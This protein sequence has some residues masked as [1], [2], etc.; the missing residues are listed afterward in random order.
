MS[1]TTRYIT[2]Q[3]KRPQSLIALAGTVSKQFPPA[4]RQEM[5][6]R[7]LASYDPVYENRKTLVEMFAANSVPVTI[8]H[9]PAVLE[10]I[11]LVAEYVTSTNAIT[12]VPET[13]YNRITVINELESLA[14][15]M[16]TSLNRNDALFMASWI[17]ANQMINISENDV[18]SFQVLLAM[19][20]II[21]NCVNL[22]DTFYTDYDLS[23]TG[24][25]ETL[26][27]NSSSNERYVLNDVNSNQ[28]VQIP[29]I[30][31]LVTCYANMFDEPERHVFTEECRC[32]SCA[33]SPRYHNFLL[34]SYRISN[35]IATPV[36]LT[37]YIY[38][39]ITDAFRAVNNMV[40]AGK[41]LF[42]A[43]QVY[44]VLICNTVGNSELCMAKTT[45]NDEYFD[46]LM[47]HFNHYGVR[48]SGIL[49]RINDNVEQLDIDSYKRIVDILV[50]MNLCNDDD[51]VEVSYLD[52]AYNVRMYFVKFSQTMAIV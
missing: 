23:M 37:S 35:D 24:D 43:L 38:I 11:R 39:P 41:D 34:T 29:Y 52:F 7:A 4:V 2:S 33:Y 42:A 8:F 44:P 49:F 3:V 5:L 46:L 22:S 25:V 21:Y 19:I 17:L 9:N 1:S 31:L 36:E 27:V 13:V 10:Q 48:G 18:D 32:I 40:V 28:I 26:I 30:I 50:F 20:T 6:P 12:Q 47:Y 51:T 45:V 15:T 16:R 14:A